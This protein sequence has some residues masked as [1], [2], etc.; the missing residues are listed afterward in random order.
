MATKST[1]PTVANGDSWSAAQ[2]NTYLRDNIEALWPYTTAGD[3]AFASASNQLTRLGKPSVDAVL[4]NTSAGTPSWL[5]LTSVKGMLH[6]IGSV[7]FSPNGQAFTTAWAD[8]TGATLTLSLSVTCTIAVLAVVT[9]Y[10]NTSGLA[11]YVRGVVDGTADG[12]AALPF[13]GGAQRNEGLPYIYR[14]TGVTAGS[15][16]VKLQCHGNGQTSY[17]ERGR[18]IAA[19]F[20]E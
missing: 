3:I 11:F 17:V 19:A 5:P 4:K 18:L 10:N 16:I 1:V 2:H 12:A 15:R 7:D 13:N 6:A 14:A 9:G 20:V 8:I